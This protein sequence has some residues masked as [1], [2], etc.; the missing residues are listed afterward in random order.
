M[1][2]E[3][4]HDP[5]LALIGAQ[6]LAAFW[7]LTVGILS[8]LLL[9]VAETGRGR[10]FAG[11]ALL[12]AILPLAVTKACRERTRR[13]TAGVVWGGALWV[14]LLTLVLALTPTGHT[15]G[16]VA[17]AFATKE[18]TFPRFSLGNL[19]PEGDQL[20]LGFTLMP[21]ADP[22]LTT[23]QASELKRLTVSLYRE[24]ESDADFRALGSAMTGPYGELLGQAW[25]NGHSYVYVPR[26]VN[27][28]TPSPV[29]V[30]FHG[31]G[32][33]FKAYLWIL[34]KLADKAGFVLVAPS[35]GMGNWTAEESRRCLGNALAAASGAV[36]V[37]RSRIHLI[38]LSNGGRASSQLAGGQGSDFASMVFLSPVFDTPQVRSAAFAAQC[39]ERRIFVVTGGRDDRVPLSYVEENVTAMK[40][41]GARVT[42]H[43]V[44][45]ADHFLM[46]S[47]RPELL[48]ILEEWFR[49]GQ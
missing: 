35:N 47:H 45:S 42:L 4:L 9:V 43:T 38:G 49:P 36:A 39:K 44:D 33:N 34:S 15:G 22:L 18:Q 41:A 3:P 27:R 6:L 8:L 21:M 46:F 26:S 16:R 48:R 37:D 12:M 2:T 29:L 32:G 17:H 23:T 5:S 24:L 1:R 25:L 31:S 20:R 14:G 19:L 28:S 11:A 13:W 10:L 7:G 30:F 40:R